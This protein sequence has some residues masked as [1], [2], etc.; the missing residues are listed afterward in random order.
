MQAKATDYD[1]DTASG[2]EMGGANSVMDRSARRVT[3]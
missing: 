1:E 2:H 3:S